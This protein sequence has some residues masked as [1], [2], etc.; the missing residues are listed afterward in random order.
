MTIAEA[1]KALDRPLRFGDA[2]Q[3]AAIKVVEADARAESILSSCKHDAQ[4]PRCKGD[5]YIDCICDC[6]DKHERRCP[7]CRG[8]GTKSGACAACVA[9]AAA[10]KAA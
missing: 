6:G 9:E 5:A 2:E 1:K 3:I 4:C 7:E 10:V 8:T